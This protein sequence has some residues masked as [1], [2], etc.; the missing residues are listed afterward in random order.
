M[1]CALAQAAPFYSL[2]R[3]NLFKL[4]ACGSA[5]LL[6]SLAS[7]SEPDVVEGTRRWV[8]DVTTGDRR[9]CHD[10]HPRATAEDVMRA[11]GHPGGVELDAIDALI[12]N[13]PP[14]PYPLP[15]VA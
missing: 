12:A 10:G 14:I 15:H 4:F 5:A 9:G 3:F 1:F 11:A 13:G 6:R 2:N 8:I 7:C